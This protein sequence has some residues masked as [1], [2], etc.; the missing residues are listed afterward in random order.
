[1]DY[2]LGVRGPVLD[3]RDLLNFGRNTVEPYPE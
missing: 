1:M 3:L 2:I